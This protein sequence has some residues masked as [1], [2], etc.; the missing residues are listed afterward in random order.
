MSNTT[1][2]RTAEP[3]AVP[4]GTTADAWEHDGGHAYRIVYGTIDDGAVIEGPGV[5]VDGVSGVPLTVQQARRLAATI[6]AAAD[7]LAAI[8]PDPADPLDGVSMVQFLDEIADR[9]SGPVALRA[10]IAAA[11]P[12][13]LTGEDRRALIDLLGLTFDA[14]GIE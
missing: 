13:T 6:M 10:A 7:E 2:A 14:A 3:A 12:A 11:D 1:H 8:R 5:H 4:P 9:V